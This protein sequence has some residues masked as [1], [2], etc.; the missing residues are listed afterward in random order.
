MRVIKLVVLT[1]LFPTLSAFGQKPLRITTWNLQWFPNGSTKEASE[2][3]QAQTISAAA[4]VLRQLDPD[5]ILL[6][7]V[8]GGEVCEKLTDAIAPGA[9]QLA[10]CS[11]FKGRQQEAILAKSSAQA[12]WAEQWKNEDGVDPPRGFA[13]A[14]FKTAGADV[15]I[16]CVHLKSN[17]SNYPLDAAENIGKR[18]AATKQLLEHVNTVLPQK[19]PAIRTVIIGGDF[20]T[21][22]DQQMFSAERTLKILANAGFIDP[23]RNIPLSQRITHPASGGHPDATFDY[24]FVKNGIPARP[25]FAKTAISDHYPVTCDVQLMPSQASSNVQPQRSG[26]GA[27]RVD[28]ELGQPLQLRQYGGPNVELLVLSTDIASIHCEAIDYDHPVPTIG[29]GVI[30]YLPSIRSWQVERNFGFNGTRTEIYATDN[31]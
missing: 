1:A 22:A 23:S 27:A 20:N 14:W 12:A 7:E 8:S 10:I 2:D 5:I 31:D 24:I 6:Q 21:N 9:Y 25:V 29:N 16:Y 26:N 15:G 18:E 17:R 13:F 4:G 3:E 30:S 28:V 11:R 19:M